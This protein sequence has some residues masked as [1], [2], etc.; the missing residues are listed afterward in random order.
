[1]TEAG[2]PQGREMCEP[3]YDG[4]E[5]GTLCHEERRI[6]RPATFQVA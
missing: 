4:L 3:C 6:S 5:T 1:M 2:V